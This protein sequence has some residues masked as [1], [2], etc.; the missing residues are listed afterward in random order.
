MAGNTRRIISEI[1]MLW[2]RPR[3]VKF[4]AEHFDVNTRTIYRDLHEIENELEL[5]L[6][7]DIDTKKF[8]LVRGDKKGPLDF[9]NY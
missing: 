8:F 7:Q 5:P 9:L 2:E 4:L 1:I 6:E 3:D